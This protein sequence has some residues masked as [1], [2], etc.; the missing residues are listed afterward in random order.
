MNT[1]SYLLGDTGGAF[2]L[3]GCIATDLVFLSVIVIGIS[4]ALFADG[5]DEPFDDED[6]F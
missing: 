3:L 2:N 5:K 6:E 1:L 4:L